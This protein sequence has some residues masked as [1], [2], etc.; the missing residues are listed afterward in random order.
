MEPPAQPRHAPLEDAL[1]AFESAF[2]RSGLNETTAQ[3]S[4]K[5]PMWAAALGLDLPCTTQDIKLAFRRLA[6]ATH[7]DRPGGSHEAFL[8][9]QALVKDALA[10]LATGVTDVASPPRRHAAFRK[11]TG[12]NGTQQYGRAVSAYG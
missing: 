12:G 5:P 7:P 10:A 11:D 3:P 2:D 9:T 6:L 8:R 1:R 4:V